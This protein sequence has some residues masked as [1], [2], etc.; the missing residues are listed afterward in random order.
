M[1]S[2]CNPPVAESA[3]VARLSFEEV[4]ML[5]WALGFFIVAIVAA[6]FGFAGIAAAAAG[7]AKFIF[8]IFLVLF[9]VSILAH[10]MRGTRV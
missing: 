9:L 7:I 5:R 1:D 6:I 10:L 4:A 3:V 8:Y 2:R